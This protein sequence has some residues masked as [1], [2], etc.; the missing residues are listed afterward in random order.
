MNILMVFLELATQ[1]LDI[2]AGDTSRFNDNDVEQ[3]LF[4]SLVS[5]DPLARLRAAWLLPDFVIRGETLSFAGSRPD[6]NRFQLDGIPLSDPQS[7]DELVFLPFSMLY[8]NK[9]LGHESSTITPVLN[10]VTLADV[11]GKLH[12]LLEASSPFFIPDGRN[13]EAELYACVPLGQKLTIALNGC[14]ML[15]DRR[16]DYGLA[17]VTRTQMSAY[18]GAATALLAPSEDI[19]VKARFLR[20]Q[21]QRDMF[22]SRWIFNQLSTPVRYSTAD[23]LSFDFMYRKRTFDVRLT[24]SGSNGF[25]WV[26]GRK[27]ADLGLFTGFEPQDT[28]PPFAE[29]NTFNPFGVKGLFYSPGSNSQVN[30]W[31]SVSNRAKGELNVMVG[32]INELRTVLEFTVFNFLLDNSFF[33][34]HDSVFDTYE[35]SPRYGDFYFADRLHFD[36]FSLEPGLRLLYLETEEKDS[37]VN[38][39][40]LDISL[41]LLPSVKARASFFGIELEAGSDIAAGL[42]P[43][44]YFLENAEAKPDADTLLLLPT[45]PPTPERAFRAWMNATK[46]L[47]K[48]WTFG[49]DLLSSISYNAPGVEL[50]YDSTNTSFAGIS[51]DAN[52]ASFVAIPS[53]RYSSE[54]ISMNLA[55]RYSSNQSTGSGVARDYAR[56]LE[57]DSTMGRLERFPSDSR[58][59]ITFVADLS[60]PSGLPYWAREWRLSPG[61]ALASGFP[62]EEV[63]GAAPWWAWFEIS[64]GRTLTLGR[65]RTTVTAEFLNP[66]GWQGPIF[67]SVGKTEPSEEDFTSRAIL[68]DADY[69]SSRDANHDGFITAAEEV[70]AYQR[71]RAFYDAWTP[72][73]IPAR[74]IELK[75]AFSF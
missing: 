41:A 3:R 22:T 2:D 57:G 23:M 15:W 62:D 48:N 68:G 33:G 75:L 51:L 67:G 30:A 40:G 1:P 31:T 53:V 32:D 61:F 59:K 36:K 7:G 55:Y 4:A 6:Q 20:S 60:S 49:L 44:F 58:H 39:A 21:T 65:T 71:A 47:W 38:E 10:L 74:S 28:T 63:G 72:G 43:F 66:F 45:V 12:A 13:G 35:Y 37:I 24:L 25:N 9:G 46:N 5:C 52:G 14:A 56:L 11:D 50:M 29:L 34:T 42:V 69:H 19:L 27:N 73:P 54:W 26:G 70:A 64:A 17:G 16:P 18:T 8:G